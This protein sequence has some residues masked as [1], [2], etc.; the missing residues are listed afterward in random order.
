MNK[1][2][3][4][5]S[6]EPRFSDMQT[7]DLLNNHTRSLYVS[8]LE[9]QRYIITSKSHA[10]LDLLEHIDREL[11]I[12]RKILSTPQDQDLH[13]SEEAV[14]KKS[15]YLNAFREMCRYGNI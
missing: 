12:H 14:T 13:K 9:Q 8:K 11:E 2:I 10:D 3:I 15:N 5:M 6:A 1:L 4:N 7:S